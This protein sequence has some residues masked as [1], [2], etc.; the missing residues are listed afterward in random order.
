MD[1]QSPFLSAK[2]KLRVQ[3]RNNLGQKQYDRQRAG[4]FHEQLSPEGLGLQGRLAM[5]I[6]TLH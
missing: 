5:L 2:S 6:L 4:S 3:Q 1:L